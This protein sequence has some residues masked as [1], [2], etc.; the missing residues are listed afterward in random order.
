MKQPHLTHPQ[1]AL[2]LMLSFQLSLGL[3]HLLADLKCASDQYRFKEIFLSYWPYYSFPR[4]SFTVSNKQVSQAFFFQ[5]C[6]FFCLAISI[7]TSYD[8]CLLGRNIR[9][10]KS[11]TFQTCFMASE[12]FYNFLWRYWNALSLNTVSI[13]KSS[14]TFH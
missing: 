9:Q 12:E 5:W 2:E 10:G 8:A 4:S 14:Y 11:L 13:S 3:S 6:E 7:A 1:K